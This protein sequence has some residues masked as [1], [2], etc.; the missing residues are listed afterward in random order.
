MKVLKDKVT[1][2]VI[3]S[4]I[5]IVLTFGLLALP[6]QFIVN[7]VSG[8]DRSLSGYQFF[9]HAVNE[10][11]YVW[12]NGVSGSGIAAIVLMGLAICSYVFYKKSSTLILLGGVFNVTTAILYFAMEANKNEVYGSWRSLVNVGWVAYV[13][14]ALLVLT[15]LLSIYVAIRLFMKEKKQLSDKRSYS[16]LKK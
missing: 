16:Y 8:V 10:D 9:F 4:L 1:L 11:T 15:G 6:G 2:V 5:A 7:S 13:A 3:A 14:G 12:S